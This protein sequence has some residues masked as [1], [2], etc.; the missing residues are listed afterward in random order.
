MTLMLVPL[1]F[2][3]SAV[4][5]VKFACM[6]SIVKIRFGPHQVRAVLPC[7]FCTWTCVDHFKLSH[8]WERPL[9]TDCHR[10]FLKVK[11][12]RILQANSDVARTLEELINV[13]ELKV[14]LHVQKIRS[15]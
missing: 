14:G 11:V 10:R 1:N 7:N 3:G 15:V 8:T 12:A 6:P 5:S 9:L 4:L 13:F 2:H